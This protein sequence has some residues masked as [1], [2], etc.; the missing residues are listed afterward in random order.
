MGGPGRARGSGSTGRREDEREALRWMRAGACSVRVARNLRGKVD[1]ASVLEAPAVKE[2]LAAAKGFAC[3]SRGESGTGGVFFKL[4][5]GSDERQLEQAP[6]RLHTLSL[7]S[8]TMLLR[9][10]GRLGVWRCVGWAGGDFKLDLSPARKAEAGKV[11]VAVGLPT[12]WFS[13]TR[14]ECGVAG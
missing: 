10:P 8:S 14:P 3:S 13:A 1:G 5:C 12:C 9:R 4:D 6:D 11:S 7:R 2:R